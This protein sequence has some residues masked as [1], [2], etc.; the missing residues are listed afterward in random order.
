[1]SLTIVKIDDDARCHAVAVTQTKSTGRI[2]C[3]K[4]QLHPHFRWSQ[5]GLCILSPWD[6]RALQSPTTPVSPVAL[7]SP[8]NAY[9]YPSPLYVGRLDESGRLL[10]LSV[11]EFC[12]LHDELSKTDT[13]PVETSAV[14]DVPA[15]PLAPEEAHDDASDDGLDNDDDNSEVDDDVEDDDTDDDD[16]AW[17]DD[18]EAV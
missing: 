13:Q 11:E 6:V 5:H 12:E 8:L 10:K 16:E 7:A 14:Y 3:A 15:I 17:N 2:V 4:K 1:M 9:V 18:L